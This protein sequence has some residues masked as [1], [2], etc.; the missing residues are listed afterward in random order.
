MAYGRNDNAVYET[1]DMHSEMGR[2]P[3]PA[4]NIKLLMS[5]NDLNVRMDA[6]LPL[7]LGGVANAD[8]SNF[9][10]IR[11]DERFTLEW[12]DEHLTDEEKS[13]WW[14]AACSD[15]FAQGVQLAE[16]TWPHRKIE[17]YTE[18]RSGGW[19]VVHG[20]E[21]PEDWPQQDIDTW[22][23]F[24]EQVRAL[25]DDVPR[26]YLWLINANVFEPWTEELDKAAEDEANT[27]TVLIVG[28]PADG[29]RFIGPVTPN[30]PALDA[31]VDTELRGQDWWYATL[32]P[33]PESE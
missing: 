28:T 12:I 4:V 6:L 30:D 14:E 24:K 22:A 21:D 1:V 7:D 25:V 19:L 8:G 31:Y 17:V 32:E 27:S 23:K 18:G 3:H 9:R 29:F 16:E 20:L 13:N 15:N 33:L 2:D 10:E 11:T 5:Y 26:A